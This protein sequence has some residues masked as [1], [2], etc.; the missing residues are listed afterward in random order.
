MKK[1]L[2]ILMAIACIS[3]LTHAQITQE[4]L[5][6]ARKEAKEAT[7]S[8]KKKEKIYQALL[9]SVRADNAVKAFELKDFVLEAD[10]VTFKWG[11]WKYVTS[12]TNFISL[13]EDRATVQIAFAGAPPGPNGIGGITVEGRASNIEIKTDKKGN[14]LFSMNVMGTAIS[15]RI[16][17]E[18]FKD[19]YQAIATVI[20]NFNSNRFTMSGSLYPSSESEVYKARAL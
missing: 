16:E 8:K 20:P 4:Q 14:T 5:D 7:S 11:N 6:K 1:I 9:D 3:D 19:T 18:L 13:S 12:N 2:L 10:M 15:A 17:I